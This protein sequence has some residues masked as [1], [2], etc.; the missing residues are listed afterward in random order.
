MRFCEKLQSLRKKAGLSQEQ[1]AEQ[2]NVTRQAISKWETG[3][4][5]PELSTLVALAR[6][7]GVSTDWL[8]SE[9]EMPRTEEAPPEP[10]KTETPAR[11]NR[12]AQYWINRYGWLA[13]AYVALVGA[14][15][16]GLGALA[17]S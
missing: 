13:G 15:I 12:G 2:M 9:E 7:F 17:R 5:T 8:L 3:E 10:P 14:G 16:A 4:A 1:L 6:E 11:K